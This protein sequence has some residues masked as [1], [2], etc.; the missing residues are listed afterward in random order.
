MTAHV[1]I[2]GR[3]ALR[4]IVSLW[5][6]SVIIFMIMRLIPGDPA[7]VSLGETATPQAIESMKHT[8]GTDRPLITQ[9]FSW[10]TGML[11]GH[12]GVSYSSGTDI[13]PI[14]MDRT[15]VSL[16]LVLTSM[17]LAIVLAV[18]LGTWAAMRNHKPDGTA[19][20][21]LAH[22]GIAIPSFLAGILLI[23][24]FAVHWSIL[25]ANGWVPPNQ[26]FT[27]FLRRLILPC[28]ALAF[29]QAAI[30]TRYVRS[31]VLEVLHQEYIRTARSTGL[32]TLHALVAHGARNAA[33]PIVAVIGV[34]MA[35]LVVGAVLIEQVFV[36]PGL[37]SYVLDAV[38]SRDMITVQSC[39][40]MLVTIT[41]T[42]TLAADAVAALIDPRMSR[43]RLV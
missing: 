6:A 15:A 26:S 35:T 2:V 33:V 13:G 42:V 41:L 1:R 4:Y 32:S 37:G 22:V 20:S 27:G 16:I 10:V 28:C 18:P 39:V 5:V 43:S 21:V 17:V 3:I 11:H 14:L 9:Y 7:E 24:L 25:P 34:N 36:I 40:M 29:I 8:L 12:F 38:N 19:L 31:A 30:L 23:S